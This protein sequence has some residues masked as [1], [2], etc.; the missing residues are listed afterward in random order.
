MYQFIVNI[1]QPSTVDTTCFEVNTV[2]IENVQ[3]TS[4]V[5]MKL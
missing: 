5:V 2:Y 4:R 3:N 1:Y